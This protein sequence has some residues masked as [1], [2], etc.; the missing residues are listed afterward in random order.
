MS[1]LC[2]MYYGKT[3]FVIYQ[4]SIILYLFSSLWGYA[5]VVASSLASVIPF[6]QNW[7]CLDPCG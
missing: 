2:H 5:E 3:G 4:I 7:Q 6:G 1:R